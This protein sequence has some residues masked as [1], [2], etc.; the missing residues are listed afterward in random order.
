M[1][2]LLNDNRK[3][4]YRKFFSLSFLFVHGRLSNF[5]TNNTGHSSEAAHVACWP[6]RGKLPA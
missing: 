3:I 4:D 6:R 1:L 2:G 5:N